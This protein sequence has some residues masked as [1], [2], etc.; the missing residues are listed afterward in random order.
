V[1][2]I[3]VLDK[4]LD[5]L[6][7]LAERPNQTVAE[8]SEAAGITK[9]TAYRILNTLEARGYVVTYERVRRYSVGHAFHLYA[10]AARH[11]DR[12][13]QVARPQMEALAQLGETVN[14]GVLARRSVLYLEVIE[15]KQG[16]RAT[17]EVGSLD[18]LHATALGKSMLSR[19]A[20]E[21]RDMLLA[22][23]KL[24]PFTVHTVTDREALRAQIEAA[25]QQGYAID[26][27]ENEIGMRCVAAPIVNADGRPVAALSVSGPNSRM[28]AG[29][30]DR[31]IA[32]TIA[33]ADRVSEALARPTGEA[34]AQR[35]P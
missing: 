24:V 2:S 26:D 14:L 22:D 10:G 16:L 27:E 18:T 4:T 34:P 19:M 28:V 20:S 12:L 1:D 17:S 29:A 6:Q 31:I 30:I 7:A 5:L 8:L 32:L 15:S 33:S 11:A 9:A 23:A 25:T 21:E 13:I 3:A 35:Q